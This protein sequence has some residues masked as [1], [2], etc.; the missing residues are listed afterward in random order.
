MKFASLTSY[1]HE[2]INQESAELLFLKSLCDGEAETTITYFE[3][4]QQ[5]GGASYVQG[6]YSGKEQI[7][8]FS[9][10]W[11]HDFQ[12]DSAS[13]DPITQTTSAGR[14]AS[15]VIVHF[16]RKKGD[17][18]IPMCIVGDLRKPNLLDSIRIYFYYGWLPGFSAYR[19]IIFNPEYLEPAPY[20]LMTGSIRKY[21]EL[22]HAE[23]D[24]QNRIEEIVS[25]TPPD[26]TYGGYRPDWIKVADSGWDAIRVHYTGIC[27]DAP[28]NFY[29]RA[30][31]IT[32]D[33]LKCVVEWTLI[34]TEAGYASG[35]VEQ[36][37]VAVYERDRNSGLLR[38]IRIC[39]NVGKEDD[40]LLEELPEEVR[41]IVENYRKNK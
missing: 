23:G 31:A 5:F 27:S 36:P 35:K 38:S 25:I 33:G 4:N 13:I 21:F 3:E 17:I 29:V 9:K 30:E 39:D 40:I 26:V 24:I 11:L 37:G 19:R 1:A 22:L 20:T 6:R 8:S 7:Y 41:E 34:V 10:N 32:D 12:A 16:N 18:D 15:E 28:K 2:G 14:S